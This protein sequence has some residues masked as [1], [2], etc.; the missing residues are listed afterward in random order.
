MTPSGF[1]VGHSHGTRIFHRREAAKKL[2]GT[3]PM[4]RNLQSKMGLPGSHVSFFVSRILRLMGLIFVLGGLSESLFAET[5]DAFFETTIRPLLAEHC[6][7][8][9]G[10]QKQWGQL[11]LDSREAMLRG[12]EHGAAI[13]PKEPAQSLLIKAIRRQGDLQMPPDEPLTQTQIASLELWIRQNA[14]WPESLTGNPAKSA[15]RPEDHWAFQPIPPVDPPSVPDLDWNQN[16]I[17]RFI[18]AQLS[19]NGLSPSPAASRRTLI[20]RMTYGITGLPPS[21]AEL[22][23]FVEDTDPDSCQH[24]V[25][26]L[27]A[28]CE[29]GEQWARHWLDVARYSDTKGYVFARE[30]RFWVHSATYRDWVVKSLQEDLPYDRFLMLQIAADQIAPD[31]PASWAAMGFLT[32]GRR[33]LGITPDI[34]DDRIDVV[35]RGTMGLTVACARCHDHKYDPI[36][37]SDYYALYSVFL[38][39]REELA[40][41]ASP[42]SGDESFD[43]EFATRQDKFRETMATRRRE[44]SER[45]RSKITEY[46]VAQ[47]DL[48]N[49][50]PEGFDQIIGKGDLVP[51]SVRYWDAYLSS[52]ER[53]QDSIFLPWVRLVKI[54]PADWS[55]RVESELNELT[56]QNSWPV[57][58][59][60]MKELSPTPASFH[61]L[62]ERYGRVFAAVDQEWKAACDAATKSES[63]APTALPDPADE[64]IRQFLYGP[65]SPCNIPDEQMNSIESFFDSDTCNELW[66]LQNGV[67]GWLIHQPV[68]QSPRYAVKLIDRPWR[69]PAFV[70]RRGNPKSK[71]EMTDAHFLSL[72]A[73]PTPKPFTT[74]SGRLELAR[75]IVDPDNPLTARVCVNRIWQHHFGEGLVTTPSDFGVRAESPSHPELLDWL[76]MELIR[77]GWSTKAIHRLILTS[78][79]YQ[80]SSLNS[81][82]ALQSQAQQKDPANRLL[83][84]MNPHRLTFEELRDSLLAVSGRLDRRA[85]GRASDLFSGNG[86]DHRRRTIYGIVD[87]QFL[88]SSLRIFDFANP[89]LHIPRRSDTVV[90]Q[91]AL[92]SLNHPLMAESAKA[93]VA[94][95]EQKQSELPNG[96]LARA[97]YRTVYQREP[98]SQQIEQAVSFLEQKLE[99]PSAE[100]RSESLAWSYGWGRLDEAS[101]TVQGFSRL[102]YFTGKAW[103]GAAE[104][105]GGGLG[106]LQ[107]T[108]DGGHTGDDLQHAVIRRWT[109]PRDGHYAIESTPMHQEAAGDGVRFHIVASRGGVLKTAVLHNRSETMNVDDI[110]LKTGDTL[111]FV[112]DFNA[113]LNCDQ[114][115]WAPRIIDR[116]VT[117]EPQQVWDA[118]RDFSG[119]PATRLNRR[120]QLAQVLL[121]SNEFVFVD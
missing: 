38:N 118:H 61:E 27:L 71:G 111:D 77:Q 69:R 59:R 49:V 4:L 32:L 36:P 112:V 72:L 34:I 70:F 40:P 23:A 114:H 9:H 20:R 84:R 108:A 98:T 13:A 33:F 81:D 78:K 120:Q 29:Y 103:Q 97:L 47:T 53:Q 7:K 75:A 31:D 119:P 79:T 94:Q 93:L 35:T 48:A 109:A 85:G 14:P 107:L 121:M 55:Q 82:G 21:E 86:L 54:A 62:A 100:P 8:C 104:W 24:L 56:S 10:S 106:W 52:P 88:A 30:E 18:Y 87:R 28:S 15:R 43:K 73:R 11:R 16:P 117:T 89:D 42:L 64:Q 12:G 57:N 76:A 60:I 63:P 74:G 92:F 17:D 116:S 3:V 46:L 44:A 83:W 5:D 90:P 115:L 58:S 102:P 68:P 110:A 6:W 113:N 41:I 22:K 101:Q 65:L 80:Q 67:E 25:E 105:P 2:P 99:D 19:K 91:Q 26:R 51:A 66:K 45:I 39:S 95:I 50:P 37:T 1:H 96:E